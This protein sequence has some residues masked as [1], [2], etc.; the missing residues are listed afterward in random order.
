M[1]IETKGDRIRL[2][3]N[4]CERLES[5]EN[6]RIGIDRCTV[7]DW[8]QRGRSFSVLINLKL[9][10]TIDGCYPKNKWFN[11]RKV[12]PA[13]KRAAKSVEKNSGYRVTVDIT[14]PKR[15]YDT[16]GIF[17]GYKGNMSEVDV[18]FFG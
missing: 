16:F 4:I 3:K 2:A 14:H 7:D 9:E 15:Q 18:T 17:S 10:C 6:N 1:D 8:D 11:L 12:T 13:I 5:K